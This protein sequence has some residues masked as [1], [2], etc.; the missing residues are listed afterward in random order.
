MLRRSH[1]FDPPIEATDP[2]LCRSNSDWRTDRAG[3]RN[4]VGVFAHSFCHQTH[5][6][7]SN[8]QPASPAVSQVVKINHILFSVE[9][10]DITALPSDFSLWCKC[11]DVNHPNELP[12]CRNTKKDWCFLSVH[13]SPS[14][15]S[16]L[17]C[18]MKY[19]PKYARNEA[20]SYSRFYLHNLWH[21][22][23]QKETLRRNPDKDAAIIYSCQSDKCY[24]WKL[25]R[26]VEQWNS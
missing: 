18:K 8:L 14:Y 5:Q 20:G 3:W 22:W 2:P 10:K 15:L 26:I 1:A 12:V 16:L 7:N 11:T 23:R 9:D 24:M 21:H 13:V 25:G 19:S 6:V 4:T 17:W